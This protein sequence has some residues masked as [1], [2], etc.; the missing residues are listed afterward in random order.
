MAE[1][2]SDLRTPLGRVRFLGSAR[3]G[4]ADAW[5][6]HLTSIALIPLTVGFAWLIVDLLRKDYNGVRAELARPIPA[7][8]LLGFILAGIVHM[9]LGMRSIIVDYF[10][11]QSR[12]WALAANT[13][14]AALLAL[15]CV[16]AT[17]RI[18]FT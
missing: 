4:T 2:P 7:I 17:L 5:F 16:Y 10:G 11:G 12:A 14:F 9:E 3:T 13:L 8:L 15:A 1:H 6:V 18:A